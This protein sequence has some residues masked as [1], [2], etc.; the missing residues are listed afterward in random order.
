LIHFYKRIHL[1]PEPA[2]HDHFRLGSQLSDANLSLTSCLFSKEEIASHDVRR[3][4]M[5]SMVVGGGAG[6]PLWQPG[7]LSP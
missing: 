7:P 5:Q 1:S 3:V 4:G 6:G 2:V